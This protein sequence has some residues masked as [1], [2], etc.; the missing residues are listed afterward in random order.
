LPRIVRALSLPARQLTAK[1]QDQ[2]AESLSTH[3]RYGLKD[4]ELIRRVAPPY[5]KCREEYFR[6]QIREAYKRN[7][8]DPREEVVNRDFSDYFAKLGWK[9]AWPVDQLT[10]QN[11]P[12]KP[13]VGGTLRQLIDMTTTF[14]PTRTAGDAE[15]LDRKVTGDFVVR[16]VLRQTESRCTP[17]VPSPSRP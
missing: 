4:D 8:I 17:A 13:D 3:D 12:I 6:D 14:G 7:K 9:D 15:L 2:L 16:G 11:T 1:E 5:P 10:K